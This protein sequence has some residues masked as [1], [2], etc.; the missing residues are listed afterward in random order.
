MGLFR[1]KPLHERL[2]EEAALD[3]GRKPRAPN[4][5]SGFL[6]D[7]VNTDAVGIHGVHRLREWDAVVTA[8]AELPGDA[9]H[10]AALPDGTLVV[11]EDVPDGALTPLADALEATVAPPY[12][13]QAVRRGERVWAAGAKRIE[14]RAF[15]GREDDELELIEGDTVVLGRR[16]DGDLFEVEVTPL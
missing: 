4:A 11:D 8:E 2:A 7:L 10:F 6:H 13:A 1:R 5:F 9:V 16:L 3:I 14:V 12:R 15:P